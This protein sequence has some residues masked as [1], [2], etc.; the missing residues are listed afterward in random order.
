MAQIKELAAWITEFGLEENVSLLGERRDMP[1]VLSAMDLLLLSSAYGESFPNVIAEAMS[2]GVPCVATDVGDSAL[3]IG[4]TGMVV[5]PGKPSELA[6]AAI[7][8]LSN[9]DLRI[10][11]GQN[12][13]SKIIGE[14]SIRKI[15]A[16]Y[17]NLL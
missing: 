10:R 5:T 4:D 8:L 12:A 13:R 15:T 17:E 3:I 11:S 1:Q 14:F 6:E 9:N 16:E 2:C 7:N